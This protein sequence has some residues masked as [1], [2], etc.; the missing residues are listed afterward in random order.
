MSGARRQ[1]FVA[2]AVFLMVKKFG[3][4]IQEITVLFLVNNLINYFL[5]PL[6]GR[7]INYFGER[8][9]LSVEYISLIFI[10]CIYAYT[11]SKIVVTLM[12]ILDHIVFNFAVAIRSHFQKIAD[13]RDIAGSMAMGVTINHIAAVILPIVGGLIWMVDYKIPFLLGA[14]LSLISLVLVQFIRTKKIGSARG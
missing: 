6:I 8:K 14:G 11:D 10:F 5:T 7:A 4:T 1:I 3:F 12:Y 9:V 2:F 13:P